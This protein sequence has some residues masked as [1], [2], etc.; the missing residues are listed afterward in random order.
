MRSFVFC[1]AVLVSASAHAD[2]FNLNPVADTFV[3]SSAAT[4]NYGGAGALSLSAPGSATGEFQSVLRF[5]V[6]AAIA[7]LNSAYSAGNWSIQSASLRLT[8]GSP[9]NAMFNPQAAGQLG[10]S[11]MQNDSWIEG[12]GTPASPSTTGLTYSTLPSFLSAGDEALG[13][14]AISEAT[15]GN[16]TYNLALTSGFTTDLNSGGLVSLRLFAADSSISYFFNSRSFGNVANRP[17]LS[18]TAIPAPG[19]TLLVPAGLLFATRRRYS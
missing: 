17:V 10:A 3:R 7:S 4:S 5:D 12:T 19:T 8:A 18:I 13:T 16:N 1:A 14:F 11:W 9:N 6:S 15:S 2:V